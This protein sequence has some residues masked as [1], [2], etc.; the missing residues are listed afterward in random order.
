MTAASLPCDQELKPGSDAALLTASA[1]RDEDG[2]SR[3]P[4]FVMVQPINPKAAK[5][6]AFLFF[7]NV[8][9]MIFRQKVYL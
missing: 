9:N 8:Q 6:V 2:D 7:T 3:N 1:D 4:T 5:K